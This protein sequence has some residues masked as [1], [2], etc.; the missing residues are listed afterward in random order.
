MPGRGEVEDGQP[1]EP[2]GDRTIDVDALVVGSA[3]GEDSGHRLHD[4]GV[5]P[6]AAHVDHGHYAAHEII[7]ADRAAW[8]SIAVV[9]G[10]TV[11]NITDLDISRVLGV[12]LAVIAITRTG[13]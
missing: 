7:F 1:T 11:W 4:G 10:S 9:P 3:V 5:R 12:R 8:E 6:S 2:E 13:S